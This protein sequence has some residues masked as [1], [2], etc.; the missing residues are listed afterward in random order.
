[1]E[2][3]IVRTEDPLNAE[4]PLGLLVRSHVTPTPLFFVRNHGAVPTVDADGYRL[5]LDGDVREPVV[6]SVRELRDDWPAATV[7]ATL[8][9]AGNRRNELTPVPDGVPWGAGAIGNAAWTGVRLADLLAAGGASDAAR[10]VAFTGLDRPVAEGTAQPFAAS[11]PLAKAL[12]PEVLVAYEMNG[13]PLAP[14]HGFPVRVVVPG[15]IGARSVKWL[16]GISVGASQSP[17]FF[18]VRDYAIGGTPLAEQVLNSAFSAETRRGYAVGARPIERVEISADGGESWAEARLETGGG[19][20]EWRLWS[21]DV[22][23]VAEVL[24]RAWDAAGEVQPE[25][26]DWNERGYMNNAWFRARLERA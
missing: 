4:T 25:T 16:A 26:A 12:S 8:A 13:E 2:P 22:D 3:L 5:T 15:Y 14:E 11:I 20:W 21:A 7:T 9:C 23:G 24:V 6:L 10:H 19:P 17:S 18:Q 1:V